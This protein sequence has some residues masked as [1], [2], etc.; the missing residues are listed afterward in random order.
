MVKGGGS[1]Q[2]GKQRAKG[3]RNKRHLWINKMGKEEVKWEASWG[4]FP[5]ELSYDPTVCWKTTWWTDGS[6]KSAQKHLGS[7][8]QTKYHLFT[9]EVKLTEIRV[10]VS[11]FCTMTTWFKCTV[12]LT[13]LLV[14][15]LTYIWGRNHC[16][17]VY[18]CDE[19]IHLKKL[20]RIL[21]IFEE[22]TP[23]LGISTDPH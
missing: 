9:K 15:D 14:Y 16:S 2:V 10:M 7:L 11:G 19:R 6:L 22:V 1:E 5:P 21:K 17:T 20:I 23:L 12:K 8:S 13:A 18:R 3:D 4:L